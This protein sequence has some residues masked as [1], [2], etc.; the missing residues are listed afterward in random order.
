MFREYFIIL[1]LLLCL[2]AVIR[3]DNS[4]HGSVLKVKLPIFTVQGAVSDNSSSVR[5][6][7]GIP[8]AEPPLGDL[9]FRPPVT[10]KP[11]SGIIDATKYKTICPIWDQGGPSVYSEYITGDQPYSYLEQGEDCL[12]VNIWTPINATYH[13][14][15]TVMIWVHGGGYVFL[16]NQLGSRITKANEFANKEHRW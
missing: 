11:V 1:L 8:Y 9:R 13:S 15:L 2:G 3:A 10:K 6:F 7:R 5:V 4:S 14:N 12:H 16:R